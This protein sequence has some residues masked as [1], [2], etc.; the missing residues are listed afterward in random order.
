MTEPD[1]SRILLK[2]VGQALTGR[3]EEGDCLNVIG[4]LAR[5]LHESGTALRQIKLGQIDIAGG[6]W[7]GATVQ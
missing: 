4:V 5:S 1:I 3:L 7:L 2:Q 6:R